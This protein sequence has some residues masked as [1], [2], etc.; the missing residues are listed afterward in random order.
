MFFLR[1]L[2]QLIRKIICL[3][4]RKCRHMFLKEIFPPLKA[5]TFSFR[6][7]VK[8]LFI[9]LKIVLCEESL[10]NDGNGQRKKRIENFFHTRFL[11]VIDTQE[12]D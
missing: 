7:Y 9:L 8:D 5:T 10:F 12:I 2:I 1:I 6:Y 3:V 4:T 11:K